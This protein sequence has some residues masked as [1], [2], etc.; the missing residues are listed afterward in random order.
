M[1][2]LYFD[3]AETWQITREQTT[4]RRV[5][6][7][8]LLR[9]WINQNW[10]RHL[11]ISACFW[12]ERHHI[13]QHIRVRVPL[14]QKSFLN[15]MN[16]WTHFRRIRKRFVQIWLSIIHM[17]CKHSIECIMWRDFQLDHTHHG[18]I[19]PKWEFDCSTSFSLCTCGYSLEK[20]G[21]NFFFISNHSSS[22]DA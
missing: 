3:E 17:I 22:V 10:R 21:K 11:W 20:S 7:S 9:W 13:W 2:I 14:H 18:Q 8:Y 15:F 6:K 16:G 12:M 1:P 4:S 19:E 5:W